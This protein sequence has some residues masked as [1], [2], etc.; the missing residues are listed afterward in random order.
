MNIASII[1]A[2]I[3]LGF[4]VFFHEFGHFLAAK[5]C[6]VGV[7]EFSIGMGPRLL[8]AV[9]NN[10]RYSLKLLPFGGSCAMLGEDDAGSG[11]FLTAEG[12]VLPEEEGNAGAPDPVV[13]FDGVRYRT[14]ELPRYNFQNKPAW[15]RFVICIAGV[16][17]NFLLALV[18]AAILIFFT[19]FDKPVILGAM[20]Q[21]PVSAAGLERGDLLESIEYA[22]HARRHIGSFRELYVWLY[23]HAGDFTDDTEIH[24]TLDRDGTKEE[25]RFAPYY[26]QENGK[27]M[28]GI[29][30]F[31]GRTAAEGPLDL[32]RLTL[33]EFRYD[34]TIVLD[35][36]RMLFHGQVKR[37]EVMGPVGTVSV[38]G[39]T[40]EDSSQYGTFNMLLVLCELM[41]LLSANL[42]VMNLLPIPAL[43][44]GRLLFILC[45]AILRK[46]LDPALEERINQVSMI[47]LLALMVMI[48]GNDILNILSGA[49]REMLSA[50]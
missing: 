11:D 34:V 47:C 27:Y 33:L 15:Q 13:D 17:N 8:S 12:T 46:R 25:V 1:I 16:F 41:G 19:G 6:G 20:E 23:I 29:N 44:G 7:L 3:A 14:S 10:T 39:E 30:F 4:L 48:L 9:W 42:G 45:E 32:L 24:V 36:L 21:A 37:Q 35:S 22:G 5:A 50:G 40:V 26:S 31:G 2:I 43:D 18:F 49:Y 38:I 28:L